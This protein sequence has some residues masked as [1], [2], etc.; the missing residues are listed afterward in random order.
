MRTSVL[1]FAIVVG[2][3]TT[4]VSA[5]RTIWFDSNWNPTEKENA[6]YYRPNPK[7]QQ[8]GYLIV[9][10]YKNGIKQKEGFGLSKVLNKEGFEG[11]V[12]YY[13]YNGTTAKEIEFEEGIKE[14]KYSE[15]YKTGELS[16]RG[17]YENNL[18]AGIWKVFYKN[19]KIKERGKYEKG[20]KIGIWKTFYKNVYKK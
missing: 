10:Y 6:V 18:K 12:T 4:S 13:F 1:L 8:D 16:K 3:L 15:Y 17:S 11:L 5:Q 7:L 19:G 14:G 20:E 9:D 2:F